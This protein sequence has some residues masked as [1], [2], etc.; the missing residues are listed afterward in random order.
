MWMGFACL[1]VIGSYSKNHFRFRYDGPIVVVSL[2]RV[3]EFL[4]VIGIIY[5][6]IMR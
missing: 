5:P 6:Y 3:A 2:K 1:D 4:L